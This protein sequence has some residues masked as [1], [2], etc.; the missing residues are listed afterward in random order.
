MVRVGRCTYIVH[1]KNFQQ[2]IKQ[3]RIGII[4]L[5]IYIKV[6]L[7]REKN[8]RRNKRNEW[9]RREKRWRFEDAADDDDKMASRGRWCTRT[10]EMRNKTHG[11]CFL[12]RS[13]RGGCVLFLSL[14]GH[15]F[16]ACPALRV[17][18][19]EHKNL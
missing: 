4:F 16:P 18:G 10:G 17:I 19:R 8:L 9:C 7:N 3:N 15:I 6:A 14:S 11:V 1:N 12:C 5:Y 2:C 13:G